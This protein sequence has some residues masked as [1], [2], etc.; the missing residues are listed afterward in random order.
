LKNFALNKKNKLPLFQVLLIDNSKTADVK[1]EE[2]KEIN[3]LKLKRHLN[4]GGSVFI[5]SN[6]KQKLLEQKNKSLQSYVFSRRNF[7]YL[8]KAYLRTSKN[9]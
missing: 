6:S 1:V 4:H 7:G 2:S 9:A 5:T 8:M 3:Y